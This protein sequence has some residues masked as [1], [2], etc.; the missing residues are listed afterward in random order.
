MAQLRCVVFG[1]EN[2]LARPGSTSADESMLAETGKLVRYLAGRGIGVAVLTNRDW[3][4]RYDDGRRV[5]LK[6]A[7]T[8][9]WGVGFRWLKA[10]ADV[11]Y[12]QRAKAMQDL[13]GMLGLQK[14]E[15]VFVGN[16]DVDMQSA[17]NGGVLL[18][19]AQWYGKTMDYGFEFAEPKEIARFVDIFCLREHFWYFVIEQ[20]GLSVYALAP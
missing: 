9:D 2:V 4:A 17:I 10:G 5:P 12:K 19:N 20:D 8:N 3:T 15:I 14:N 18:L 11:D 6:T 16:T 1:V 7:L 13:C